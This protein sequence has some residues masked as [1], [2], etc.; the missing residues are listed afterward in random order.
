M[1]EKAICI[2]NIQRFSLQDGPGIRTTVFLK[3]CS[4]CCPWCCNP[5][6]ISPFPQKMLEEGKEKLCGKHVSCEELYD[7]I[8]KDKIYYSDDGGVTFSGG[9]ALLQIDGLEA[10]M[11]RLKKEG[12]HIC[13]ETALFVPHNNVQKAV[14]YTN[15]FFV[16]IKILDPGSCQT[17][18]HGNIEQYNRN[19]EYLFR[20][21]HERVIL[22]IPVIGGYTS[23][24][25]N[26]DQVLALLAKYR[27]EKVELLK[28]HHLG[29][30]KY[31][32][33]KLIPPEHAEVGDELLETYRLSIEELGITVH[34]L[35]T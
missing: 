14:E 20:N 34:I 23:N 32:S 27:P 12:I 10:L 31:R 5:E 11:V 4:L 21:V 9:E 29:D 15:L 26:I 1:H 33:L 3:G 17:I 6:T 25:K 18:L 22:R 19:L 2:S 28:G 7:E 16:D 30:V 24:Q 35:R 13:V 8:I